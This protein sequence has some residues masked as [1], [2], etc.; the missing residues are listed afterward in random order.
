MSYTFHGRLAAR[1]ALIAATL[2]LASVASAE[3]LPAALAQT[4][5]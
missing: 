2:A 3:I 1:I 4:H 5:V